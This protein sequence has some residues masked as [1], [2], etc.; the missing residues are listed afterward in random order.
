MSHELSTRILVDLTPL[1]AYARG[2]LA[3]VAGYCRQHD[4]IDMVM[5]NEDAALAGEPDRIDGCI[6]AIRDRAACAAA[7]A[8]P[9]PSVNVS[10]TLDHVPCPSVSPHSEAVGRLAAEHLLEQGYRHFACHF[11]SRFAFSQRCKQAFEDR[12]A[13]AGHA[14]NSFDTSSV[15]GGVDARSAT[16][17][18]LRELPKPVGVFTHGDFRASELIDICRRADIEVPQEAGLIGN[19]NDE[20]ICAS[21]KPTLTSVDNAADV[22]GF[23]AAAVLVDLIRGEKP[24]SGWEH[25]PPRAV[26][27]RQSTQL[28]SIGDECL[29]QAIRFIRAHASDA[30]TVDDVVRHVPLSRRTLERRC[31]SHLARSPADEIRRVHFERARHLLA[32]TSIKLSEVAIASGYNRFTSFATAFYAAHKVTPGQ[33][34]ETVRIG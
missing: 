17:D 24:E 16:A 28:T 22:I 6:T 15:E 25:I 18:W 2:V 10:S 12:L 20:L 21:S 30:I 11:E 23:R 8:S 33:Y 32:D 26:I 7:A 31:Q 29:S 1:S 14:C 4:G 13:D 5:S 3:G 34:R 19:D 9:I 27:E